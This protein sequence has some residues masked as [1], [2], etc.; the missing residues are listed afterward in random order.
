MRASV[1]VLSI[2]M[3]FTGT[4]NT[5]ATKYQDMTVV[6]TLPDGTPLTFKH[7]AVQS[8]C[9]F[10]G[11][12]LCLIPYFVMRWRKRKAKRRNPA[13]VPMHPGE[14]RLKGQT[15][16]TGHSLQAAAG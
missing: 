10:F 6:G 13:Y 1:V 2:C 15:R 16:L 14:P 4:I 7:P 8:A 12:S 5:I 9:M 11:E 3:L